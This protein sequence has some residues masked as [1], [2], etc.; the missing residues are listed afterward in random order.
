MPF[1]E[2][3]TLKTT[4]TKDYSTFSIKSYLPDLCNPMDCSL[5]GSS[6]HRIFQAR[7]LEWIAISFSRGIFLTQGSNP[8]L[9]HCRQMLYRLSHQG[10]PSNTL[11][12]Y[13]N[14]S[15]L[16]TFSMAKITLEK[17]G[18]KSFQSNY[19]YAVVKP[20]V[21]RLITAF[22]HFQTETSLSH[23]FEA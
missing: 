1:L 21:N 20:R 16:I 11:I 22:I 8:G 10:S 9:P 14:C 4:T 2:I 17:K 23:Y 19:S 15:D 6:V 3:N 7:V 18:L 12:G 5:S 13:K